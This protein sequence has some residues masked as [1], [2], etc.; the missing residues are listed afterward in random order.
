MANLLANQKIMAIQD[1]DFA[2]NMR[3]FMGQCVLYDVALGIKYS[4]KDLRNSNNIW[5]LI[6][7]NASPARSFIWKEGRGEGYYYIAKKGRKI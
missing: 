5:G 2:E 7:R 1:E 4:I 6:S 3:S